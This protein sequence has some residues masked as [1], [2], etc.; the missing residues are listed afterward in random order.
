MQGQMVTDALIE[1]ARAATGLDDFGPESYRE[2]LEVLVSDIGNDSLRPPEFVQRN[3]G[4]LVKALIDRLNVTHA[5]KQRPELLERPI[6]R[7]V[8]V[9]GI[10]R[11]GTTLLN[12]LLAADP[13][14]RSPLK[15]ELD[16]PV[17]PPTS[18]TLYTD[19]R[20]IAALEAERQ[21][22]A[23]YPDSAKYYRASATYPHECVYILAH[24]FKTLM[25]D[26]MGKMPQYRDYI[27]SADVTSA[28][29]YHKRFLQLHQADAPGIWN[30]KMPSHVLNIETL[31]KVYPDARLVWIHRDPF[32]ATCS[33]CSLITLGHQFMGGRLDLEWIGQNY[34]W[35]AAQH[36]ERGMDARDRIGE[37]RVIDVQYADVLR[38]PIGAMRKL[39][40]ALGDDFTTEAEAAMQ[41]WL[42]DNPQDK[43]GRHEYQFAKFGLRKEEVAPLFERY[44]ARYDVELEG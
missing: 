37:D 6:T 40:A 9:F 26:S 12:N 23:A 4:M 43:F 44:L 33:L 36:A 35:Q 28:Y 27:F 41:A 14:R 25:W 22:Y 10:P 38:N 24:D 3:R 2:G 15:W 29:E 39:Y 11:T 19:P 42:D 31:L 8:F 7:P 30:L 21:L 32:S 34:P 20:A 18:A 5:L 17:P 16:D 13:A 1:D